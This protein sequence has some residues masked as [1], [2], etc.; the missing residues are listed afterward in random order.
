MSKNPKLPLSLEEKGKLRKA[1]VKIGEIHKL[2]TSQIR[3]TLDV[4]EE[5]ARMIK[6][7]ADFQTVPSVGFELAS[8][9]VNDLYIFSL[10]EIIQKDGATLFDLLEKEL[11]V[12]TDSCVED[13]IRCVINYAN[14]T[15]SNKQ[16]FDFTDERKIYR[17]MYGYPKDRPQKAWYE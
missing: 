12:W 4:P 1:K 13:Q 5:R 9:L 6:G 15:N 10:Q 17:Q 7:L 11:G 14:N 16:W 2:S 8:K 3:K